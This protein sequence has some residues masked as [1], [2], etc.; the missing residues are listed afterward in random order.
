VLPFSGGE[1]RESG[2]DRLSGQV[3]RRTGGRELAFALTEA[4]VPHLPDGANVVFV[5]SGTEDPERNVRKIGV[6]SVLRS[7]R[8]GRPI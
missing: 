2:G 6:R 1:P 4:L 7:P 5:C 8:R 3:E